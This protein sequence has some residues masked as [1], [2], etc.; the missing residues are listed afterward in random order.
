[1]KIKLLEGILTNKNMMQNENFVG[2]NK[3]LQE[4][5]ISKVKSYPQISLKTFRFEMFRADEKP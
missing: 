3:N 1:M 5:N 2:Y 4:E